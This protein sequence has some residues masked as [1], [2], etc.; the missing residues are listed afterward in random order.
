MPYMTAA[1]ATAVPR[2]RPMGM[3]LSLRTKR[4]LENSH[5]TKRN[6]TRRA[7]VLT[8]KNRRN[9]L[10]HSL[11]KRPGLSVWGWRDGDGGQGAQITL[12]PALA[13]RLHSIADGIAHT[14]PPI[15]FSP[16][17]P[18]DP[19]KGQPDCRQSGCA[20]RTLL[21]WRDSS[22]S[23]YAHSQIIHQSR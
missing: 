21:R 6:R 19:A 18:A 14:C 22:A 8:K 3:C 16:C 17:L 4:I 9:R 11:R 20:C 23:G 5:S 15:L 2:T 12:A 7:L 13:H 1:A 10:R